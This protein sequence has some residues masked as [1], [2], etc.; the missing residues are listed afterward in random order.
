MNCLYQLLRCYDARID[1]VNNKRFE[2]I[3]ERGD[4]E[5]DFAVEEIIEIFL[6]IH[7]II[8]K[9]FESCNQIL[10]ILDYQNRIIDRDCFADD[11]F[12]WWNGIIDDFPF[13]SEF[14][15]LTMCEVIPFWVETICISYGKYRGYLYLSKSSDFTSRRCKYKCKRK[16]NC[17][18]KCNCKRKCKCKCKCHCNCNCNC[19]TYFRYM[20]HC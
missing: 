6:F 12:T 17:K 16:C 10:K 2:T 3:G 11:E 4:E 9:S 18:H 19:T 8:V 13:L 7:D 15:I 14:Y 1:N 5:F 20:I